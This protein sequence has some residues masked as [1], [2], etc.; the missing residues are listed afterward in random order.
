[1]EKA[2][3]NSSWDLMEGD[4]RVRF[5]TNCKRDVRR[6]EDGTLTRDCGDARARVP[7]LMP[8][9]RI[10]RVA[11][12]VMLILLAWAAAL[13]AISH[14]LNQPVYSTDTIDWPD[15]NL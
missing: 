1:M 4:D 12:Y 7:T 6:D 5:C 14:E 8:T 11:A 10:V 9:R 2:P 13:L 15:A 3:C